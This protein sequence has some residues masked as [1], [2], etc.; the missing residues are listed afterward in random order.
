MTVL[1][2]GMYFVEMAFDREV[3]LPTLSRALGR[4]GFEGVVFDQ[5]LSEPVTGATMLRAS[6]PVLAAASSP[7]RTS[8]LSTSLASPVR[9]APVVAPP[10][11]APAPV[12][13]APLAPAVVPSSPIVRAPLP[14]AIS[15]TVR[16]SLPLPSSPSLP[17]SPRPVR[18]PPP[19]LPVGVRPSLTS[20][21]PG[22]NGVSPGA[23]SVA[24]PS[25]GP[26]AAPLPAQDAVPGGGGG[27]GVS[28]HNFQFTPSSPGGSE[29][30]ILPSEEVQAER[31]AAAP[32]AEPVQADPRVAQEAR[33]KELWQRW[34]EWGSPF[35]S[36]PRTSGESEPLIRVRFFANLLHPITTQNQPGMTW[37]LAHRMRTNPLADLKLQGRPWELRQGQTYEFRFLA[38]EKTAPTRDAVRAGLVAMGFAPMKLLAI[39]KNMRLPRR[40]TS[41][42]LW[43]GVGQWVK[44]NSV[45]TRDDPFFFEEV[46]E[47]R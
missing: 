35:A 22:G 6:S 24:P 34:V 5:S 11:P 45:V 14:G 33:I 40:P 23:A 42:T 44:P 17:S 38:R 25:A 26:A 3:D 8:M 7:L 30:E 28:E 21:T 37:L 39:K 15:S 13:K 9:A 10:P 29:E 19:P 27:G 2:P 47:V 46:K 41:L 43:Y 31:E 1:G 16:P 4:M 20:S 36:G 12:I 32:P 18:P